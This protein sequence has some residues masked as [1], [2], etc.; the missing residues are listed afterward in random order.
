[1]YINIATETQI[2]NVNV[3]ELIAT[4]PVV[5]SKSP[6]LKSFLSY[7]FSVLLILSPSQLQRISAEGTHFPFDGVVVFDFESFS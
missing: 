6:I 4:S 5:I 7:H 3:N 2:I 1:M